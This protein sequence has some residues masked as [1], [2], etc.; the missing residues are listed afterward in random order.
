MRNFSYNELIKIAQKAV[1]MLNINIYNSCEPVYK[2][3][4]IDGEDSRFDYAC[5]LITLQSMQAWDA[6][7]AWCE[8][9]FGEPMSLYVGSRGE[10]EDAYDVYAIEPTANVLEREENSRKACENLKRNMAL[11]RLDRM[12]YNHDKAN[13]VEPSVVPSKETT[14]GDLDA[15]M[16]L[17]AKMESNG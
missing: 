7:R 13:G 5:D 10:Y 6:L 16:A 9:E 2:A 4:R 17:K 11:R 15:L 8:E 14:L 1:E 12:K 3:W